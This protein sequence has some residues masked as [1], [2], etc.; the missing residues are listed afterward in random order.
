MKSIILLSAMIFL[1]GCGNSSMDQSNATNSPSSEPPAG[2]INTN[3]PSYEMTNAPAI[4]NSADT[5][6]P[7][8]TNR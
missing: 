8:T 1:A 7:A 6:L 3:S 5:N 2:A 4:T